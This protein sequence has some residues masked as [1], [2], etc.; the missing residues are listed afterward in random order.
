MFDQQLHTLPADAK[1]KGGTFDARVQ[2]LL[3]QLCV[4]E[5]A[6]ATFSGYLLH[7]M[8]RSTACRYC[9]LFMRLFSVFLLPRAPRS[10]LRSDILR[11]ATVPLIMATLGVSMSRDLLYDCIIEK[12]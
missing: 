8:Q 9:A 2:W 5:A 4:G 3:G 6:V 11:Q 10:P 7:I 12:H 1:D